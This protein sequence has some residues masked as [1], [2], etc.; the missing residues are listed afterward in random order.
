[1]P[2]MGRVDLR[3][4]LLALFVGIWGGMAMLRLVDR[5]RLL[6]ARTLWA[7]VLCR[8]GWWFCAHDRLLSPAKT[9]RPPGRFLIRTGRGANS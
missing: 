8:Y 2:L 6:I 7:L 1:M 9:S 3:I 5:N 4:A